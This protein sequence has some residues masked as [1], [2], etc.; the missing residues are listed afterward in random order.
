MPIIDTIGLP[1]RRD[2]NTIRRSRCAGIEIGRTV[3]VEEY[4][5]RPGRVPVMVMVMVMVVHIRGK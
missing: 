1:P 3:V 2:D 5:V 4:V